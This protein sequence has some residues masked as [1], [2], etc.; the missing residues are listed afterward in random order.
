MENQGGKILVAFDNENYQ[1][2]LKMIE[3]EQKVRDRAYKVWQ[4]THEVGKARKRKEPLQ[5]QLL[6]KV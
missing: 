4:E 3:N 2:L 6:G 1:K 5:F